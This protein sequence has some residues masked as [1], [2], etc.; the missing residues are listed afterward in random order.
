MHHVC[1]VLH[2]SPC[3]HLNLHHT[4]PRLTLV[5]RCAGVSGSFKPFLEASADDLQAVTQTN[6]RGA[7][8]CTRA[9]ICAMMSNPGR[10]ERRRGH[11]FNMD[12]AGA[13]GLA[14]AN[15][16]AYGATKA[17]IAS[18]MA[19]LTAECDAAGLNVGVHTLSPG[20]VLTELLLDGATER[21]KQVFNVLCE[22]PETAAAYLVPRVRSVV[23]RQSSM[24]YIRVLTSAPP[25][26]L[27]TC[28]PC[29]S[30][31]SHLLRRCMLELVRRSVIQYVNMHARN[32][33]LPLPAVSV[34]RLML[35]ASC[36]AFNALGKFLTAPLRVGRYFTPDGAVN[37]LE[38][39]AERRE[40]RGAKRTA[41]ALSS[42]RRRGAELQLSYAA[43]LC[44]CVL[45][46]SAEPG[47]VSLNMP[48]AMLASLRH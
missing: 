31:T 2:I 45:L 44:L 33:P 3:L 4:Q 9:A 17:G 46:L 25:L 11:V 37:Y 15:Y 48:A 29:P 7:L 23:A 5:T 39:A 6:L 26:Q 1:Y 41:R 30:S 14:T 36:A 35:A 42:R 19:S 47:S 18:L 16:A 32:V 28:S 27:Q 20:M 40:G 34:R 8:L 12:G 21:N 24:E 43:C 38:D 10:D 13:D 22:H